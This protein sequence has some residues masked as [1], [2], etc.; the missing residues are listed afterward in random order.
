MLRF[1]ALVELH[2]L[3]L[4]RCSSN[5]VDLY[6]TMFDLICL[7]FQVC[8]IHPRDAVQCRAAAVPHQMPGVPMTVHDLQQSS[9]VTASANVFLD[10]GYLDFLTDLTDLEPWDHVNS[11]SLR[12]NVRLAKM[13]EPAQQSRAIHQL[14]TSIITKCGMECA[15]AMTV[16]VP[17][18][19]LSCTK[20]AGISPVQIKEANGL[21]PVI[22]AVYFSHTEPDQMILEGC[23]SEACTLWSFNDITRAVTYLQ[24]VKTA[25]KNDDAETALKNDDAETVLKNKDAETA[26][27]KEAA[28]TAVKKEV[29]ETAVNKEVAETAVK[30]EVVETAVKKEVA[31]T[32]AVSLSNASPGQTSYLTQY[33]S[34]LLRL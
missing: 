12:L 20:S 27:K 18:S 5:S 2:P 6:S 14:L 28:E 4:H 3:W 19:T 16:K 25:A 33:H 26:L 10:T 34:F 23:L 24:V 32:A 31:E 9:D 8:S 1:Q 29:A 13:A 22:S 11:G 7:L 15:F 21:C 17:G 30:K